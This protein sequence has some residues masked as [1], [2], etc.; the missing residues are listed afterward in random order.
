[1]TDSWLTVEQAAEYLG[2]PSR[3]ALYMAIRRGQVPAYKMGKRVRFKRSE[4]DQAFTRAPSSMFA[5]EVTLA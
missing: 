4:L 2:F 1:M 5:D 3:A